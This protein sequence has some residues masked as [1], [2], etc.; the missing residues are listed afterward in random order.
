MCEKV[1]YDFIIYYILFKTTSVHVTY[2]SRQMQQLTICHLDNT[3]AV[4][5]IR[6]QCYVWSNV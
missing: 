2:L 3:K 4:C 6:L 5:V 1:F